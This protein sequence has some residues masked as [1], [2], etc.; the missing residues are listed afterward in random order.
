M[1][2]AGGDLNLTSMAFYHWSPRKS[3]PNDMNI[4]RNCAK[5]ILYAVNNS[6]IMNTDVLGYNL[7]VWV[8]VMII[9]DCVLAVG[10]AVWGVFA[11]RKSVRAEKQAKERA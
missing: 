9:V 10:L 2:Y 6:N 7:P 11:I 3:D 8:V 4:L 5:N 1:A